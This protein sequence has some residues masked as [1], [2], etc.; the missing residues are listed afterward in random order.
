MYIVLQDKSKIYFEI[1]KYLRIVENSSGFFKIE[2]NDA[3]FFGIYSSEEK[4]KKVLENMIFYLEQ[5]I[6]N[7]VY[8]M[9]KDDEEVDNLTWEIINKNEDE[10]ITKIKIFKTIKNNADGFDNNVDNEVNNFTA[11]KDVIEIKYINAV[12][13]IINPRIMVI[14]KEKNIPK[15]IINKNDIVAVEISNTGRKIYN[16]NE[17]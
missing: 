15:N 14:Y 7:F 3:P 17:S 1:S 11:D 2:D 9:P 6:P 5:G 13:D 8:R 10:F 12:K 4:T 16:I